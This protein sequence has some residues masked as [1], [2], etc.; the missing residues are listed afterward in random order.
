MSGAFRENTLAKLSHPVILSEAK[1][2]CTLRAVG[3]SPSRGCSDVSRFS[4][5]H[6]SEVAPPCHPE[7]SEGPMYFP[8]GGQF[9][10]ARVLRYSRFWGRARL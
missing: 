7:R 4:G 3:S 9:H 8:R 5:E 6:V 2:L 10:C 1:D